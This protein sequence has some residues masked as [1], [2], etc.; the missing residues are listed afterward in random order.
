M[1]DAKATDKADK[2]KGTRTVKPVYVIMSVTDENGNQLTGLTKENV[3]IHST[4]KDAEAVLEM[5]ENDSMPSG[6]FHKRIPLA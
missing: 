4:H 3:T 2:P 6:T 5:L 1:A